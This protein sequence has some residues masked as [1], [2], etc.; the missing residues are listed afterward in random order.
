[1][2]TFHA[3]LIV[4]ALIL[5]VYMGTRFGWSGFLPIRTSCAFIVVLLLLV[6]TA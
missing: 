4:A 1:M 2:T 5:S 3:Y 6:V